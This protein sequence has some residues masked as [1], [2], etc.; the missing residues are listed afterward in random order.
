M[1]DALE[2]WLPDF[3]IL[4]TAV[5]LGTLLAV[6]LAAPWVIDRLPADYFSSAERPTLHR[7][8]GPL[9][10]VMVAL[11][12]LAGAL[13]V[14]LGVIMLFTPGQGLLTLL[15]GV[16]LVNFPGKYHLE[17]ALVGRE[18]VFNALNWLRAR[19][20]LPPFEPPPP[21]R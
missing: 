7:P 11:K 2:R 15:V 3:A 18:P 17:R 19:R 12:N 20:S 14:L 10:W 4:A 21:A 8:A 9:G 1:I 6:L 13:L 5:S 16:V